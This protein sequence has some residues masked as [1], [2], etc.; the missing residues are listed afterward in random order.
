MSIIRETDPQL[1]HG[2]LWICIITLRTSARRP[3]T[4][5]R[6]LLL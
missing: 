2:S 3:C 4:F 1:R 6:I 5:L